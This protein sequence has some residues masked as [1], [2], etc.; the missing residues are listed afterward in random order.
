MIIGHDF[1]LIMPDVNHSLVL[2]V[3]YALI[4]LG[5]ALIIFLFS[6]NRSLDI[7]VVI[8]YKYVFHFNYENTHT[9]IAFNTTC[10]VQ[11]EKQLFFRA[12]IWCFIYRRFFHVMP[13]GFTEV[14]L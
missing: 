1:F 3:I 11:Q 13:C 5:H 14:I 4:M 10:T 8:V 2:A 6:R 12:M 9:R 7:P